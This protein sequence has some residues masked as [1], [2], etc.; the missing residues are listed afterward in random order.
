MKDFQAFIQRN[1]ALMYL[2][3]ENWDLED[4]L[5]TF[6]V[7]RGIDQGTKCGNRDNAL[8]INMAGM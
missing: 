6:L 7:R 3:N 4:A 2:V 8:S 1:D 5:A